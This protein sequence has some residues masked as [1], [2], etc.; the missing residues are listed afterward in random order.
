MNTKGYRVPLGTK[1]LGVEGVKVKKSWGVRS[2]VQKPY[3]FKDQG[4][5]SWYRPNQ[6]SCGGGIHDL[7]FRVQGLEEREK[8]FR[9]RVDE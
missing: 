2:R 4:G 1:C 9:A 5:S 7:G 6:G 8:T 3:G